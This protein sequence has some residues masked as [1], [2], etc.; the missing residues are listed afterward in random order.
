M[1]GLSDQGGA[2]PWRFVMRATGR[3]MFL[4]L[5]VIAFVVA[6]RGFIQPNQLLAGGIGGASLLLE[7][8]SG[9]PLGLLYL[10][11]NVPIFF[12]GTRFLGRRFAALSAVAVVGTWVIADWLP[13]PQLTDD[14]MLAGIFGG[15]VSGI[16]TA[17]TMRAGGSLGGFDIVGVVINRRFN[18]GVGEVL[19]AL[20]A[21]LVL[22]AGAI[23]SPEAAMY[24][25]IGIFATRWTIDSLTSSRPRKAFL[26]IT[27]K[28]ASIAD[29][30]LRQMGR[31]V[32][33]LPAR[34][35]W[36]GDE[37]TALLCVVTQPEMGEVEE[38]V[39]AADPEAFVVVL[40]ASQ[41]AGRFQTPPAW[42]YWRRLKD[43]P[44]AG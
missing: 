32:T 16:G 4:L 43:A 18:L 1:P 35:A 28:P 11:L 6:L 19:L 23:A 8:L 14:P 15:A 22:A 30:I 26:V 2:T 20:N 27:G 25:L 42:R 10:L 44:R 21:G 31:G 36:T 3:A 38:V 41:V 34:G 37:L 29:R 5:G 24:T 33:A 40:E 13:I 17:L 39:R 9:L 7:R 12:L